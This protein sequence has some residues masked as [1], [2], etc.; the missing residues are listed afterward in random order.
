MAEGVIPSVSFSVVIPV[1]NKRP[2]VGRCIDSVLAQTL[3]N[4]EIIVIDDSSTDGSRDVIESFCDSRITLLSRDLPGPGGYAARNLG[5]RHARSPWVA[6]LDAD[7][8]W[9]PH[10]LEELARIAAEHPAAGIVGCRWESV[11]D[12]RVRP[13]P[14]VSTGSAGTAVGFADYLTLCLRNLRPFHTSAVAVQKHVL[15]QFGGFP[16]GRATHGGDLYTWVMAMAVCRCGAFSHRIGCRYRIDAVNM[17]TRTVPFDPSLQD[18]VP[19][20]LADRLSAGELELLRRYWNKRMFEGW[21]KHIRSG[22][23]NPLPMVARVHPAGFI[24]TLK[25]RLLFSIPP[26][27]Y[28]LARR[29][30]RSLSA[31]ANRDRSVQQ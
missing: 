3:S 28:R 14:Y 25:Y 15:D 20:E 17:V 8:E 29:V 2:H 19:A 7:D 1:R 31:A 23:D 18:E 16:E 9:Y 10:H 13:A 22:G 30:K 4:F 27:W 6:F 26:A 12:N 24:H 5:I 11:D 21:L